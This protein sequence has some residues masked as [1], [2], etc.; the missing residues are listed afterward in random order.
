MLSSILLLVVLIFLNAVFAS[1]EIAIISMN[2]T[3]LKRMVEQKNKKAMKLFSL[4]EQPARFLA[5]VQVAITLSGLLNSAFA[6]ENFAGPLVNLLVDTGVTIPVG[7]LKSV[8]LFLITLA[9]A[10]FNLVFGEL[11]PKRIAM[12]KADSMALGMAGMLYGV[13]KIFAPIVGLLT[14]STNVILKLFGIDPN[15]TE[16]KLTEEELRMILEEG[17][18]QGIIDQQENE[19]IMN[20]FK[21]AD[22]SV[23]QICTHRIDVIALD[24]EDS[25][26]EWAKIIHEKKHTYYPVY[27]DTKDNIT[28]ILDAKDYFRLKDKRIENLRKHAINDTYFIPEEMKAD[29]LFESMRLKRRYFAVLLDEYGGMSGIITV[30][31]LIE[32]IVGDL[33]DTETV[34]M[35]RIHPIDKVTWLVYGDAELDDVAKTLGI[36]LPTDE[37]DTFNGL[38]YSILDRI[39]ED[40]TSF[41]CQAYQLHIRVRSVKN[42]RIQEA[43]VRVREAEEEPE[44]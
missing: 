29:R 31:D 3:K 5:T 17:N 7:I 30:H 21:F 11:V 25:P 4:T 40:D 23:E 24:E 42:H 35:E 41:E 18:E 36:E 32:A 39:P 38:V 22:I 2:E 37:Y 1:A 28:G 14:W 8:A 33:Y 43:L 15:E 20:L 13:S 9:L 12:K 34:E 44:E 6:A 16:D 19:I 26:E 27:K 10:Y